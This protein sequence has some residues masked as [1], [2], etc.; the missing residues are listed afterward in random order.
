MSSNLNS[1]LTMKQ[2]EAISGGN[3][4]YLAVLGVGLA[5]EKTKPLGLH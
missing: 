5:V 1:E 3:P 2:M 4:A